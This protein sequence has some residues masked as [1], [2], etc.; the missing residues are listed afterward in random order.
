VYVSNIKFQWLPHFHACCGG[1]A[2]QSGTWPEVA[3]WLLYRGFGTLF[4]WLQ[5]LILASKFCAHVPKLAQIRFNQLGSLYRHLVLNLSTVAALYSILNL[6]KVEV[7]R[8]QQELLWKPCLGSIVHWWLQ[9]KVCPVLGYQSDKP[10]LVYINH[11]YWTQSYSWQLSQMP[12][13][14]QLHGWYGSCVFCCCCTCWH[15]SQLKMMLL[16]LLLLQ[17]LIASRPCCVYRLLRLACNL[18]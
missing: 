8:Y 1:W 17:L 3:V 10:L 13:L 9:R 6:L 2:T 12:W 4:L 15:V 7:E 16:Q 11:S 18:D 14:M 5:L